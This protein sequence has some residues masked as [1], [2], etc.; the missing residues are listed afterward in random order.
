MGRLFANKQFYEMCDVTEEEQDHQSSDPCGDNEKTY[1]QC[2]TCTTS[3]SGTGSALVRLDVSIYN[4][5]RY[6]CLF[7][8]HIHISVQYSEYRFLA[9][10]ELWRLATCKPRGDLIRQPMIWILKFFSIYVKVTI[11][12]IT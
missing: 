6:L 3:P 4:L 11:S 8:I 1:M 2:T 12:Q 10:T 7:S 5:T 9:I